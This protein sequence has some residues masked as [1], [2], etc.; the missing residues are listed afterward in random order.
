MRV[1]HFAAHALLL[2]AFSAAA[3]S[4]SGEPEPEPV[5]W[6]Q[7][8]IA[9]VVR[10]EIAYPGYPK[11]AVS[12]GFLVKGAGGVFV[13]VSAH[14][15]RNEFQPYQEQAAT[16][17]C[18]TLPDANLVLSHGES[19]P[20]TL[21]HQGCAIQ[22][23]R[24]IALIPVASRDLGHPTLEIVARSLRKR[25]RVYLAGFANGYSS[26]DTVSEGLVSQLDVPPDELAVAHLITS[27]GMS[28]GPLLTGDGKVVGMHRGGIKYVGG[29]SHFTR[30]EKVKALLEPFLGTIPADH[31][32]L[33]GPV[34]ASI[35]DARNAQL[36]TLLAFQSL[37]GVDRL[38]AWQTLIDRTPT[39]SE[40]KFLERLPADKRETNWTG[41]PLPA[42]AS[43]TDVLAVADFVRSERSEAHLGCI[44]SPVLTEGFLSCAGRSMFVKGAP[45]GAPM[46]PD[47]IVLHYAAASSLSGVTRLLTEPGRSVSV[48]FLIDRDGTVVQLVPANRSAGHA[49]QG[50]WEGLGKLNARSVAIE[51]INAGRV[52]KDADDTYRAQGTNISIPENQVIAIRDGDE[53]GY[54][55]RFT[56]PQIEAAESIAR[57]LVKT[58]PIK[59]II[60]HC[61]IDA[62]KI[63]P[64]PAF[65]QE[66]FGNAVLGRGVALCARRDAPNN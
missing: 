8:R 25:D 59:D 34:L 24:D 53:T 1:M 32:S 37:D 62:R 42:L 49:G 54:W 22:V 48:H 36:G 47:L 40:R 55:H 4:W 50:R 10:V 66:A 27:P 26:L 57:E 14:G 6:T 45:P 52:L 38:A 17:G 39:T 65:P 21:E 12:T 51:F 46:T 35:E 3:P 58:Y 15:L 44:T 31:A 16:E 64:G 2:M 33:P 13:L 7:D 29:Y 23:G 19:E 5:P 41:M 9:A 61:N 11:P 30:V 20:E 18:V 60:G 63:D 56:A 28:G 43:T